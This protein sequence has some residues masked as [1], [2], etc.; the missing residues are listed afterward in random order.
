M[1]KLALKKI[2]YILISCFFITTNSFSQESKTIVIEDP[3]F[4]KL[5]KEKQ[6]INSSL[7]TDDFYKIQIYYGDK[8]N[9]KKNL[10][11]FKR[12]F[13]EI[14]GTILYTNPTYKVWVGSFKL[15][16]QAE[17]VLL[18]VKKKYPTAFLIKKGK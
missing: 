6:Q 15:R 7:N 18:E 5:L 10:M 9:A 12:D 4:S 13:K 1:R 3:S 14:D 2:F 11:S 8:E 17:K 16:I